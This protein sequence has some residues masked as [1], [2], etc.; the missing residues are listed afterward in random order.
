LGG[1]GWEVGDRRWADSI[2]LVLVIVLVLSG[3]WFLAFGGETEKAG[4][5]ER[6]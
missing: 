4:E 6:E 2:F 1:K 3:F 5:R